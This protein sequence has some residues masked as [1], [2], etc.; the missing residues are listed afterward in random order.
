VLGGR[1]VTYESEGMWEGVPRLGIEEDHK[2]LR[3]HLLVML[4][5]RLAI[6]LVSDAFSPV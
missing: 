1:I 6:L 2:S 4:I 3:I 5:C